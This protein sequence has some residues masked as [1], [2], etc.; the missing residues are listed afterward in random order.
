MTKRRTTTDTREEKRGSSFAVDTS[1]LLCVWQRR[2]CLKSLYGRHPRWEIRMYH[3]WP[4]TKY[5][6]IWLY[7]KR[8]L[9]CRPRMYLKCIWPE[10]KYICIWLYLHAPAPYF[11]SRVVTSAR[12]TMS[13]L[14]YT[15]LLCIHGPPYGWIKHGT[16]SPIVLSA[17]DSLL[18]TFRMAD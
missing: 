3:I 11:P 1:V 12:R 18:L 17:I 8:V 7:L 10:A 9:G 4:E 6:C 14:I 5:I 2:P 16:L 13:P 15:M